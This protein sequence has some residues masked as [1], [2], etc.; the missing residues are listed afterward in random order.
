MKE[1]IVKLDSNRGYGPVTAKWVNFSGKETTKIFESTRTEPIEL[2]IRQIALEN[3]QP[4]D[5]IK[6]N[7]YQWD[8]IAQDFLY[9]K[10]W[11]SW[12]DE[13]AQ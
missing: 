7:Y 12:E 8:N 11:L 13:Y 4:G 3:S 1:Y 2:Y 9:Y 5:K 10:T 6:I